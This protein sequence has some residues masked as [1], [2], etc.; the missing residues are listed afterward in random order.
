MKESVVFIIDQFVN[1]ETDDKTADALEGFLRVLKGIPSSKTFLP[2]GR[3][4]ERHRKWQEG[5]E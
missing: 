3:S 2:D 5:C 1:D 4:L